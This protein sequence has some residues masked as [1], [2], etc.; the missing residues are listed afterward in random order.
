MEQAVDRRILSSC[1]CVSSVS[2]LMGLKTNTGTTNLTTSV[3]HVLFIGLCCTGTDSLLPVISLFN[4][5]YN[6]RLFKL[7]NIFFTVMSPVWSVLTWR[8]ESFGYESTQFQVRLHTVFIS[9]EWDSL[10]TLTK[11]HHLW[12]LVVW[13]MSTVSSKRASNKHGLNAGSNATT[14]II[15]FNFE[16]SKFSNS[17]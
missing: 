14:S 16:V 11:E 9:L 5:C 10:V 7:N 15:T 8:G 6:L 4:L 13:H 3:A 12:Y 17:S 2:S 1:V